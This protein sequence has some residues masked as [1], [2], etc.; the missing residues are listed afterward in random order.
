MKGEPITTG[1]AAAPYKID[2]N[3][4]KLK[5]ADWETEGVGNVRDFLMRNSVYLGDDQL[6]DGI[7]QFN[8]TLYVYSYRVFDVQ[9]ASVKSQRISNNGSGEGS[10]RKDFIHTVEVN[11]FPDTLTW[12]HDYS[13]SF[14][15]PYTKNYF[16]HPAL[17][18]ILLLA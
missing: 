9:K 2:W 3:V 16:W 13:Y 15:D 4:D 11:I 6:I 7:A 17:M 5:D 12:T 18:I 1:N 14:N 8:T 10:G